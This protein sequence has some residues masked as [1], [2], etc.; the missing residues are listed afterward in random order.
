MLG[1][2]NYVPRFFLLH[3]YSLSFLEFIYLVCDGTDKFFVFYH[4]KGRV[5]DLQNSDIRRQDAMIC[6]IN[7]HELKRRYLE[8]VPPR[9]EL[10]LKLH[11]T[12]RQVPA[13]NST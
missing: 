3:A 7:S 8:L 6:K 12:N 13:N 2:T 5:F 10:L 11:K 1:N 4:R 9:I